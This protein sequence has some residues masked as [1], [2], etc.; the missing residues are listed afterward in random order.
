[1]T[2]QRQKIVAE[3]V[4]AE[5]YTDEEGDEHT[6]FHKVAAFNNEKQ[7]LADKV[8]DTA[9][10]GDRVVARG[11]GHDVPVQYSSGKTK[12]ERQLWA[13][14]VKVTPGSRHSQES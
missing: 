11:Y 7:S 5:H 1:V 13:F 9:R 14:A 4:V 8:R 10:Q 3:F 2:S 12:V 6:V